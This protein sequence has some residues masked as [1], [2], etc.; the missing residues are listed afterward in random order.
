MDC[1][2]TD[3]ARRAT[4]RWLLR[5]EDD[6]EGAQEA[7]KAAMD[8]EAPTAVG[9]ARNTATEGTSCMPKPS[10]RTDSTELAT[11][12][13]VPY[14][15]HQPTPANCKPHEPTGLAKTDVTTCEL[16]HTTTP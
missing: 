4:T 15:P 10:T 3:T 12:T 7:T 13:I 11:P 8:H 1:T 16:H 6:D 5:H 14:Q 2:G 9:L